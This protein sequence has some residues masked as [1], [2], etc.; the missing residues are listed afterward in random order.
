MGTGSGN[1]FRGETQVKVVVKNKII[2][3]I[4]IM[5]YQDD[6]QFFERAKETNI[7]KNSIDVDT[8]SGA[9][10]SSDGIKEAVANALNID[11]TNPNSSSLYQE[12]Y[13]H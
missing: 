8:V 4:E 3:S 13:H 1:G 10:F 11:F 5:S 12:H 2:S 9:T 7:I 6:E